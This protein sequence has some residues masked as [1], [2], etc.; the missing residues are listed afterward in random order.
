MG[1]ESYV[2]VKEYREAR[3]RVEQK[4]K[5]RRRRELLGD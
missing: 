3:K 2:A 4:E 5:K 1:N